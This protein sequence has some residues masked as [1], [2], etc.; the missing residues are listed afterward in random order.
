MV[1][2]VSST[3]AFELGRMAPELLEKL[4]GSLPAAAPTS[5]KFVPG[6]VPEPPA[7]LP[8]DRAPH[9]P[10]IGPE[11]ARAGAELAAGVADEELRETIA[12]AAAAS[13]ARARADRRF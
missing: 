8:G 12:R 13:L 10:P 4:Q 7:P 11:D 5:L 9:P 3:W 2:T 6:P 1:A